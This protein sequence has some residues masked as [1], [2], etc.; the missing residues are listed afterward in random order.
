MAKNVQHFVPQYVKMGKF[1][2]W[3]EWPA[4]DVFWILLGK[5]IWYH[6]SGHILTSY[7]KI[8]DIIQFKYA[9]IT[10]YMII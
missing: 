5:V 4:T 8:V 3:E 10:V 1:D 6:Y 2:N 7:L 9:P